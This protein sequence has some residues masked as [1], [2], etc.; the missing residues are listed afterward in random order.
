MENEK[1]VVYNQSCMGFLV[2]NGFK[3]LSTE[4]NKKDKKYLVFYFNKSQKLIDCMDFYF[5]NEKEIKKNMKIV[6]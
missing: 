1:F 5:K 6:F 4:R 3:L 2:M